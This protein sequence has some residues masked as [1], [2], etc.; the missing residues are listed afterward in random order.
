MRPAIVS[1]IVTSGGSRPSD[2][3]GGGGVGEGHFGLKIRGRAPRAPPLDPLL[4]TGQVTVPEAKFNLAQ[5]L[6]RF[7]SG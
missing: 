2:K 4:V 1:G 3:W 6:S 7:S 5:F